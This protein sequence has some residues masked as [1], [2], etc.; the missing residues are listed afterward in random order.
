MPTWYSVL[1][2]VF[3][4]GFLFV[5]L[6]LLGSCASPWSRGSQCVVSKYTMDSDLIGV[7][8]SN[9]RL[10][11]LQ[12]DRV[13]FSFPIDINFA[14][15]TGEITAMIVAPE[16]QGSFHLWYACESVG[17]CALLTNDRPLNTVEQSSRANTLGPVMMQTN[18]SDF[19]AEQCQALFICTENDTTGARSCHQ[20]F[21][22][23]N[24]EITKLKNMDGLKWMHECNRS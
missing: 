18:W 20:I 6:F 1:L 11:F 19:D 9:T 23:N 16:T 5:V 22:R 13:S 12:T 15:D 3:S 17:D 21:S 4:A 24:D 8:Q 7:S 10:K 2:H 14:S